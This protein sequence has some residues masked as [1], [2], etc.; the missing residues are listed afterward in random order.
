M[1]PT[2]KSKFNFTQ[3]HSGQ[4]R[5]YGDSFNEY[6]ITGSG[7]REEVEQFA[8][9]NIATDYPKPPIPFEQWKAEDANAGN[10][11]RR[12]YKLRQLEDGKWFYQIIRP[13]AD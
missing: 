12:Y 11:F 2:T 10:H 1:S 5:A 6:E 8:L 7:T 3:T 13:F 4:K 9:D